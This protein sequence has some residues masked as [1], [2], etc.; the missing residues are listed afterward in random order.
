MILQHHFTLILNNPKVIGDTLTF[1]MDPNN[2]VPSKGIGRFELD[3]ATVEWTFTPSSTAKL[4]GM[5]LNYYIE[6]NTVNKQGD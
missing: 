4:A 6:N 2:E 5:I 1:R 3:S